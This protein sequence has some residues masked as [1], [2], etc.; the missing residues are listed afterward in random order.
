MTG[1]V[2]P[3]FPRQGGA[4]GV[5]VGARKA[6]A[7]AAALLCAALIAPG[8][9]EAL[10]WNKDMKDQPSVK[11]QEEVVALP[12]ASVPGDGGELDGPEGLQD[13]VRERIRAGEVLGD[14]LVADEAD[15]ERG[16]LMYEY[17]CQACHGPGGAGNGN[18]GVKYTPQ[19]MDLTLPY[20]QNQP[21]GQLYY[22]ITHGGVV[23]PGYRFALSQEDR[24]RVVR[25]LRGG[26]LEQAARLQEAA[27]SE[28]ASG[29]GEAAEGETGA[30]AAE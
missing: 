18:V 2:S 15:G 24:W 30:Q 10:P 5:I 8:A 12:A 25:Y 7:A 21:D 27:E 22:T 4:A 11:A 17:Y 1:R 20:V 16:A 6:L 19:P 14:S 28:A 23:M 13:L 3:A 26:L 9:V 29:E